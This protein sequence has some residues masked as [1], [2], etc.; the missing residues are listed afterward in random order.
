MKRVWI[1]A[2]VLLALPALVVTQGRVTIRMASIAPDGSIWDRNLE[3]MGA[4]WRKASGG[5]VVLNVFPGGQLGD[6]SKVVSLL[7]GG[8]PEAA[9]LTVI[10]LSRIDPAFN[11]FS[12]PFFFE[13]YEE[14][15]A[16]RERLTPEL[17]ARLEEQ[18]FKR[19][20]WGN[21][22]WV[23]VFSN[24]PVSTLDELKGMKLFT[25]AG[26]DDMVQWYKTNGFSPVALAMT[27][28]QTGLSTGQIDAV[29]TTPTA[30]LAFQWYSRTSHML[31]LGVAPLVAGILVN[32]RAWNRI[33]ENV[34]ADM[35]QSA[36]ALED[37]LEA[38]IPEQDDASVEE[39]RKRGLTV[40]TPEG[41]GW[42]EIAQSFAQSLRGGLVPADVYDLAKQA[43][44]D[45]RATHGQ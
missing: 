14:L 10:G 22:G 4:E 8:R 12:M 33:P 42:T 15:D 19:L 24:A 29:P 9:A 1:V 3:Q 30:A 13:S 20:A 27:D 35:L 5:S 26:E 21:G 25:S 40:H 7:R 44:D 31:D 38:Q 17:D 39:M 45:Y 6:D 34:R 28:I 2:L 18:G 41:D 11:V 37:R 16:I 36:Q 32:T 23:R 43:R